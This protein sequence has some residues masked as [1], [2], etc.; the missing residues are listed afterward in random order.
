[1]GH[2]DAVDLLQETLDEEKNADQ[3]LNQIAES[4]ANLEAERQE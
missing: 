3:E 4:V 1:M 2:T